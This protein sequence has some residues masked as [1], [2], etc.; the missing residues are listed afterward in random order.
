MAELDKEPQR[1]ARSEAERRKRIN[2]LKKI[3]LITVLAAILLPVILCIILLFRIGRLEHRVRE[4]EAVRNVRLAVE[5]SNEEILSASLASADHLTGTQDPDAAGEE[6]PREGG[7]ELTEPA[8]ES[9]AEPEEPA[10][11]STGMTGEPCI[12]DGE[13][14]GM[15]ESAEAD[16]SLERTGEQIYEGYRKVYLTFDDGPSTY[17]DDI[18]DILDS[19]GIKATFFVVGKTDAHST[20]MYRRI[21]ED[22]HTLGMHSYSHRYH[23]IYSSVDAFTQDLDRLSSYLYDATGVTCQYYRFPGGS[24]NTVSGVDIQELIDVL[25][26]REITYFDWNVASGDASSVYFT[27]DQLTNNVMYNLEEYR[28]AVVLMHDSADKPAS[29]EALPGIIERILAMDHTVI[30]PISEDTVRVQ[31]VLS[32][33]GSE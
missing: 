29:V 15:P 31:H 12:Q 14:V 6:L 4:L 23:E 24:S 19:Y 18:L 3:I 8:Q 1:P 25:E 10:Q 28:T 2:R 5:V 9:G 27:A 30:L 20:E 32:D 21:V 11:E 13:T 16:A 26:E 33:S 17:T 22:G 7:V